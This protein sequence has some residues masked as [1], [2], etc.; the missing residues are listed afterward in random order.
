MSTT[1]TADDTTLYYEVTGEGETVVFVGDAGLGAW[2][3]GWQHRH[4]SGP[5][6]TV[7]WDLRGTGRSDI[8]DGPYDCD[9]LT[10][11]LECVLSATNTSHCHLVGAGLGG[12]I[13][14]RYARE[15]SRAETLALFNTS[16]SG[17]DV[18]RT[19]LRELCGPVTSTEEGRDTFSVGFSTSFVT[20][21]P[22]LIEQIYEWR[23][24]EDAP[25]EGFSGQETAMCA[26]V[27]GPLYEI[28][29]PT[30]VCH[31]VENPVVPIDA[32]ETLAEEL[33]RG[34]F[35]AVEGRHLCHIEH[36]RPVTDHVID[37]IEA[38]SREK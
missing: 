30:L 16:K 37:F 19:A 28:T 26:F 27:A 10:E 36:S 22:G 20:E 23:R 3:W 13:A 24:D 12:M 11:D 21:N 38:H 5:Y 29:T 2:Q 14:L 9:T 18:D 34:T 6:R 1:T 32:G 4:L 25:S 35:E 15:Y 17:D 33:P 8:P 7:A 31:G